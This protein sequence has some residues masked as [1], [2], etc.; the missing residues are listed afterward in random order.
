MNKFIKIAGPL[1]ALT[2]LPLV[3]F[4]QADM[5]R[6]EYTIMSGNIESVIEWANLI[7]ALLAAVAAVKLSALAQG[8]ALEKT[9]NWFAIALAVFAVF[10]VFGLMEAMNLVAIHGLREVMELIFASILFYLA[11][12][13]RKTLLRQ[14]T[15]K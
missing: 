3:A 15:G 7:I 10:E 4:A 6:I 11:Y 9:W 5:P 13:T 8:G 12:T 1:V 2:A 14:I